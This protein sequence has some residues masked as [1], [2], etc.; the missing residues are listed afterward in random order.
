MQCL[1]LERLVGFPFPLTEIGSLLLGV[2]LNSPQSAARALAVDALIA[3]AELA[4][5]DDEGAGRALAQLMGGGFARIN[6]M[7]P[8]MK[9]AASVGKRHGEMVAR[10]M[11]HSLAVGS[12]EPP[13]QLNQWILF[14]IELKARHPR[15]GLPDEARAWLESLPRKGALGGSITNVLK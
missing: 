4:W 7:L 11:G 9:E 15:I 12:E 5:F 2:G 3:N 14:L 13:R 8:C 10:I 1:H 6:R